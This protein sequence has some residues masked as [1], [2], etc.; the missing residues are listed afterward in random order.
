M[1]RARWI[2]PGLIAAAL[3]AFGGWRYAVGWHPSERSFPV[4][5]IDVS[6][7]QGR[8]DWALLREQGVDFVYIKASEGGDHKDR[9]FAANLRGARAAGIAAG[10]YHFFTLCR[11][12]ADQ[13]ANFAATVPSGPGLLPPVVDLE[14]G[15]NCGARPSR[16]ALLREL[17]AFLAPAEAHAGKPFLLYLTE[18]F[19]SFYRVSEAVDRPLWLR[20][21]VRRPGYGARPWTIWQASNF[22]RLRG[23]EGRVDWNAARGTRIGTSRLAAPARTGES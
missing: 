23:I 11:A 22:R 13:A 16:E 3:L 8:I 7:H 6:H 14:F 19:D 15:G 4:Q 10:A 2:G 18:E 9:L 1:R 21:L 5:G 12:G 20:S 17:R